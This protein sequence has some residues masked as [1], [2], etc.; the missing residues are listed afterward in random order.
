MAVMRNLPNYS[1]LVEVYGETNFPLRLYLTFAISFSS[2]ILFPLVNGMLGISFPLFISL[3]LFSLSLITLIWLTG[4]PSKYLKDLNA[5]AILLMAFVLV[6]ML[7]L[8]FRRDVVT[9]ETFSLFVKTLLFILLSI[10]IPRNLMLYTH[11]V[12][13]AIVT[14]IAPLLVV[15][16]V[17]SISSGNS[18]WYSL[19]ENPNKSHVRF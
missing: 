6:S 19:L 18:T 1:N 9:P 13:S 4:N 2:L 12:L 17:I 7:T 14:Y 10:L 11:S 8:N 15:I 3:Y 16:A 5:S